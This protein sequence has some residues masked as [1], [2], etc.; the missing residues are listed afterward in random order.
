MFKTVHKLLF[1][2]KNLPSNRCATKNI[3]T[4]ISNQHNVLSKY[5]NPTNVS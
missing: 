1:L 2:L 4:E 3:F 5:N